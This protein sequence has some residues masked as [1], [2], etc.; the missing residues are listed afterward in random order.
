VKN[1]GDTYLDNIQ[2]FDPLLGYKTIG[3]LAPGKSAEFAFPATIGGDLKNN[4]IETT[5]PS[6]KDSTDLP[7]EK[8]VLPWTDLG[9][10]GSSIFHA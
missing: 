9:S 4:A 2:F 6:L 10:L 8:D 3:V 1:T 7:Y 5:N